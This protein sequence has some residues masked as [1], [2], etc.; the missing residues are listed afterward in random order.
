M[1]RQEETIVLEINSTGKMAG[2]FKI[3]FAHHLH[4]IEAGLR[5]QDQKRKATKKD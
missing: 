4:K 1:V 5:K 2:S 3:Q